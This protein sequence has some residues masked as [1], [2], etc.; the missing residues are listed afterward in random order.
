MRSALE[1]FAKTVVINYNERRI[2]VVKII[3]K[4]IRSLKKWRR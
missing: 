3:Y 4:P 2:A 1:M